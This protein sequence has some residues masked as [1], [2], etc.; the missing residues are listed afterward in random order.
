LKG[1]LLNFVMHR[2]ERVNVLCNVTNYIQTEIVSNKKSLQ[3]LS[4]MFFKVGN[5]TRLNELCCKHRA[6]TLLCT[7]ND[8]V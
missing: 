4:G 8:A 5:S 7:T 1:L 2:V 6:K 3:Q